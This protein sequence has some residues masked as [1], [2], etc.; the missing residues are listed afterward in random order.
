[1]IY[2]GMEGRH[3]F[4]FPNA[5]IISGILGGG[6]RL[7]RLFKKISLGIQYKPSFLKLNLL[8]RWIC[9]E[10]IPDSEQAQNRSCSERSPTPTG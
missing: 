2:G 5:N 3:V 1:M 10:H 8:R 7:S 4:N 6:R 9:G